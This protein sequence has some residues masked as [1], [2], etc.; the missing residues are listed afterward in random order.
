MCVYIPNNHLTIANLQLHYVKILWLSK[1][2]ILK[3]I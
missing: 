2:S 1:Y 3:L